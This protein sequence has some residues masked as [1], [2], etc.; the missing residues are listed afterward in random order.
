MGNHGST[1]E[2]AGQSRESSLMKM[3]AESSDA[4]ENLRRD[5][6]VGVAF[7]RRDPGLVEATTEEAPR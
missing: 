6:V 2:M 3:G 4:R 7:W 5:G 1:S